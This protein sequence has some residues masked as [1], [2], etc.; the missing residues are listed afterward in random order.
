MEM[1]TLFALAT[2]LRMT[3][4]WLLTAI[5][6]IQLMQRLLEMILLAQVEVRA[7]TIQRTE[8]H[9]PLSQRLNTNSE[10]AMR[11]HMYNS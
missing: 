9:P 10:R 3:A 5:V 6:V 11:E 7:Y 1:A 2:Y 8:H 4:D